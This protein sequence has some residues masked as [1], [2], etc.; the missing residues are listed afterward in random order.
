MKQV[1]V[2]LSLFKIIKPLTKLISSVRVLN[3]GC[4]KKAHCMSATSQCVL[5]VNILQEQQFGNF[6]ME[7]VKNHDLRNILVY[8]ALSVSL[9]RKWVRRFEETNVVRPNLSTIDENVDKVR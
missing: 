5:C 9:I 1:F 2:V 3:T 7:N 4:P 6:C 8:Q